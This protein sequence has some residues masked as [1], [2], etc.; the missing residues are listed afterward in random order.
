MTQKEAVAIQLSSE[1][2]SEIKEQQFIK[3]QK[4]LELTEQFQNV[5]I[6]N[7]FVIMFELKSLENLHTVGTLLIPSQ[8]FTS[9]LSFKRHHLS[10]GGCLFNASSHKS[11]K[12][13]KNAE[14]LP[15]ETGFPIVSERTSHIK[16]D[17]TAEEVGKWD[18][19][20]QRDK[21]CPTTPTRYFLSHRWTELSAHCYH[22]G[23]AVLPPLDHE[24]QEST[25]KQS[26]GTLCF[27][28][29]RETELSWDRTNPMRDSKQTPL[30]QFLAILNQLEVF[31]H[32]C[33]S[34][35]ASNVHKASLCH[36]LNSYRVC[37]SWKYTSH[38]TQ[39]PAQRNYLCSKQFQILS[40]KYRC[41][42][43]HNS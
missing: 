19:W 5:F 10:F 42:T 14:C 30:W 28:L 38:R 15:C 36:C 31:H 29:S 23:T 16:P 9:L 4:R 32:Y 3:T 21:Q 39:T 18:I 27:Q 34:L 43:K 26:E 1:T 25:R 13:I 35:Q 12:V 20:V 41:P 2:V 22:H 17:H 33:D 6:S 8:Q 37:S 40:K 24:A 11:K 7:C